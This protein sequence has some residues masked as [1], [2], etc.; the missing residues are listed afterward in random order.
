[1]F[2]VISG[3]KLPR[4]G[5]GDAQPTASAA[6]LQQAIN[7][8]A[9]SL[10]M[11][12]GL[13]TTTGVIDQNTALAAIAVSQ[14]AIQSLGAQ[15]GPIQGFATY[16]ASDANSV[17]ELITVL[18]N[19]PTTATS[20]FNAIAAAGGVP[21]PVQTSSPSLSPMAQMATSLT[22]GA[23]SGAA[24]PGVTSLSVIN[25]STKLWLYIGIAAVGA[26]AIGVTYLAMRKPKRS[27]FRAYR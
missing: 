25:S 3:G 24:M 11:G 4:T 8:A 14:A 5:M 15:S 10:G 2:T 21:T 7:A 19:D 13:L 22:T 12:D 20:A 18:S 1:M 26:A 17:N 27:K 23:S 9:T 6:Y 16:S